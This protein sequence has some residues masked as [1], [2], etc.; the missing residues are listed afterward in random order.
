VARLKDADL[1]V[2]FVDHTTPDDIVTV[3][4]TEPLTNNEAWTPLKSGEMI[5]FQDGLPIAA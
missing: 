3:I 1:T 4:A 5:T 2:D